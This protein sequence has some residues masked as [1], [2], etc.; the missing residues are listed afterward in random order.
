VKRFK[1]AAMIE[2]KT[3][4]LMFKERLTHAKVASLTF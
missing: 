4:G 3:V 1:E 2:E